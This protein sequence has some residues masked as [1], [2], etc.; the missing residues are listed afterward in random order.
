MRKDMTIPFRN[1]ALRDELS[2]SILFI[3]TATLKE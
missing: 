2:E 3:Y 1:T